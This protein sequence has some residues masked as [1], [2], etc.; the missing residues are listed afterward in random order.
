MSLQGKV[1]CPDAETY[2]VLFPSEPGQR[3][4]KQCD[5]LGFQR[6]AKTSAP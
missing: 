6:S 3:L 4:R 2:M 5:L 1:R